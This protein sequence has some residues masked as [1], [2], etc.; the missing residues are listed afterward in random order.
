MQILN[1][2]I[3]GT[4]PFYEIK[5]CDYAGLTP[6]LGVKTPGLFSNVPAGRGQAGEPNLDSKLFMAMAVW[7]EGE[8]WLCRRKLHI[9]GLWS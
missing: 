6:S 5:I 3:L 9:R 7:E 8:M 4:A 2:T 1:T